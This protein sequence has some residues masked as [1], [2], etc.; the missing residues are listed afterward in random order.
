MTRAMQG[1]G[2]ISVAA[3]YKFSALP[4]CVSARAPL[5]R[6]CP[7]CHAERSEAQRTGYQERHRQECLAAER[8]KS[9]VGVA[10]SASSERDG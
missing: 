3:L 5:A 9:H 1:D 4:D 2:P 8:G 6:L 10:Q 7:A